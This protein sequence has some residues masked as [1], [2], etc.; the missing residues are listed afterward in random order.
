MPKRPKGIGAVRVDI[1]PALS[2]LTVGVGFALAR[3]DA[4]PING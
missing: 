4:A 1:L 2:R 3:Q